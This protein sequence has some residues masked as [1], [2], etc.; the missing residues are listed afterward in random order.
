MTTHDRPL[1]QQLASDNYAGLC[2]EA[3]TALEQAN[4]GYAPS[5]GQ[6]HWTAEACDQ[7][8]ELFE[9]PCE[10]FFVFNGTA[11]NA[12][13]L[14]SLCQSYHSIVCHRYAHVETDECGAPEFF[15]HGAK[16]L[17]ADGHDGKLDPASVE[18]IVTRRSD[19]HYPKPRVISLTQSTE[20]GTV[21]TL[22]ELQA[23]QQVACRHDLKLH[24]DGARFA[25]AVAALEL[26]PRALTIED[27]IVQA[28]A[29][30]AA[31][32]EPIQRMGD[33]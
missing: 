14:A 19:I 22:A 15:S 33:G 6:D 26:P 11:A 24:L 16:L 25:N 2:P 4:H 28:R 9:T 8:R 10:V 17:L 27:L 7:F 12:L 5:Y 32:A 23:I 31:L 20:L 13:A 21:Y 1:Q 30:R 3:L 29:N 18:E